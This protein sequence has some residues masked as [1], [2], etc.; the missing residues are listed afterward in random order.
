MHVR[1]FW[2]LLKIASCSIFL[3]AIAE[4]LKYNRTVTSVKL[5]DTDIGVAEAKAMNLSFI[6]FVSRDSGSC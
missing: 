6:N 2:H 5:C 1:F 4:A 3:Q